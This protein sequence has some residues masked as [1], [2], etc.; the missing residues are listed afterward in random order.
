MQFT[1]THNN[2][3]KTTFTKS[4]SLLVAE[5]F[6]LEEPITKIEM[7]DSTMGINGEIEHDYFDTVVEMCE[8]IQNDTLMFNYYKTDC[9]MDD[10][11]KLQQDLITE[12]FNKIY[13]LLAAK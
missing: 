11:L 9:L 13:E 1:K 10:K 2:T 6:F 5:T 4:G 7:I 3:Y 12:G 8:K